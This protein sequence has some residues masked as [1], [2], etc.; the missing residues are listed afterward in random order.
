MDSILRQTITFNYEII[1]VNDGSTDNSGELCD[2]FKNKNKNI[3]VIHRKNSSGSAGM[4]RNTGLKIATGFYIS[5][6]DSDDWIHPKMIKTMIHSLEQHKAKV[7]ECD[8]IITNKYFLHPLKKENRSTVFIDNRI[9]ALTR[10][11]SI[12]L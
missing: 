6:I 2:D 4:A 7:A 1:L 9:E 5:F 10:I 8:L 12:F 11:I 3:I